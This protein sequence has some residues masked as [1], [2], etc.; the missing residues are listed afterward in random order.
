MTAISWF[1]TLVSG[2]DRRHSGKNEID[3]LGI[4]IRRIVY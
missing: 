1:G 3:V 4:A 2:E